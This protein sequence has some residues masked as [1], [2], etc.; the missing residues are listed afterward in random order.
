MIRSAQAFEAL[1]GELHRVASLKE[2]GGHLRHR[3]AREQR[4]E[5]RYTPFG[6]RS[7]SQ[8]HPHFWP[9]L[10]TLQFPNSQRSMSVSP[11][12]QATV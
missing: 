9:Y 2:E 12:E 3:H 5:H 7:R 4:N 1:R 6:A 11:F 8:V 10:K